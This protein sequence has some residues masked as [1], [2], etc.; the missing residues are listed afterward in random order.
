MKQ[1]IASFTSLTEND[2]KRYFDLFELA[3]EVKSLKGNDSLGSSF[4]YFDSSTGI[5]YFVRKLPKRF[6]EKW[7]TTC[8]KYKTN[9][10]VYHANFS[11]FVNFLKEFA[12]LRND[13]SLIMD[14][15]PQNPTAHHQPQ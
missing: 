15:L 4:A 6:R 1:R 2:R 5:N 9:N 13:P 14:N 8:Y 12:R 11:V 3:A 10:K 7:A